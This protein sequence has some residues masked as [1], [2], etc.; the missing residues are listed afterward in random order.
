[1]R[2][3][4]VGWTAWIAIAMVL[5]ATACSEATTEAPQSSSPEAS[6]SADG[7][8]TSLEGN[9]VGDAGHPGYAVEVPAGWSS[10]DGNFV[11]KNGDGV[12]GMSVWDV[13]Q[14]PRDP[15]HWKRTM[16]DVGPSVADL[17][18]ALS[19]QRLRDATAPVDMTLAGQ[20]GQYLELSVPDDWIVTGDADFKG[21]DDPGNGHQDF[22][23]WLGRD[24][25]DRYQQVAGQVDRVWV[26]DVE[27]QTLLVDATYAPDVSAADR[28]ELDQVVAS[29][30]FAEA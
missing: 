2:W 13:S 29:I 24:E 11:V 26:L 18:D 17:V 25:G 28:E 12:L 5:L 15:C 4:R 21:C 7:M 3:R 16:S 19:S 23:S 10:L 22:V 6:S 14:V 30:R 8:L 27:G 9:I 1:M 20:D